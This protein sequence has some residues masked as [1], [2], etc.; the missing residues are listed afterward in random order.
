MNSILTR[1]VKFSSHLIQPPPASVCCRCFTLTSRYPEL[2]P[3]VKSNSDFI[4]WER[5]IDYVE[6]RED[7][8]QEPELIIVIGTVHIGTASADIVERVIEQVRPD[9]VVVELDKSRQGFLQELP[10]IDKQA[11]RSRPLNAFSLQ[12]S[13]RAEALFQLAKDGAGIGP[14]LLRLLLSRLAEFSSDTAGKQLGGEF[15]AA[16]RGTEAIEASGGKCELILGDRPLGLTLSFAWEEL[17]IQERLRLISDLIMANSVSKD[18]KAKLTRSFMADI[19]TSDASKLDLFYQWLSQR[20]PPL[21]KVLVDERDQYLAWTLRRSKAVNGAKVVVGVVGRGHLPGINKYLSMD[22]SELRFNDLVRN[23][24]QRGTRVKAQVKILARLILETLG[25][26]M[27][28][29]QL[30]L[31]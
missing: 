6:R 3:F 17:S 26:L 8:Y 7:G 9:C 14:L 29:Q 24:N 4:V 25:F 20:Y 16:R 21:V 11:S 5:P 28:L 2:S 31:T 23:Q 1:H 12:G 27:I 30:H 15:K 19:E 18:E 10:P 22:S 13:S